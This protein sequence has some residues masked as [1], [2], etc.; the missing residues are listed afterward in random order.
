MTNKTIV[1]TGASSGIGEATAKILVA[2]GHKLIT[3]D[4]QGP[5]PGSSQHIKCDLNDP[6]AIESA[7]AEI[8]GD[9]DALLNV[10]GVPGTLAG[11]VV[12]GVNILGLRYLSDLLIPRLK[13]GGAIASIASALEEAGIVRS[14]CLFCVVL[15]FSQ[16]KPKCDTSSQPAPWK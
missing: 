14:C 9:I 2:E 12:I 16:D 13:K 5:P 7:V 1:L 3:L 10:A 6:T 8:D 15:V 11:E 4:V